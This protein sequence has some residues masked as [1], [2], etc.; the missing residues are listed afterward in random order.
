MFIAGLQILRNCTFA[1][2]KNNYKLLRLQGL[3]SK[4]N[5]NPRS[6]FCY[7]RPYTQFTGCQ[8]PSIYSNN[9]LNTTGLVNRSIQFFYQGP[10]EL[11]MYRVFNGPHFT[12]MFGYSYN[13]SYIDTI[14]TQILYNN[15][16]IE[17]ELSALWHQKNYKFDSQFFA[18]RIMRRPVSNYNHTRSYDDSFWLF[19]TIDLTGYYNESRLGPTIMDSDYIADDDDLSYGE[20]YSGITISITD[21]VRNGEIVIMN[22]SEFQFDPTLYTSDDAQ[23][24]MTFYMIKDSDEPQVSISF[25]HKPDRKIFEESS[26]FGVSYILEHKHNLTQYNFNQLGSIVEYMVLTYYGCNN[27]G[28]TELCY[29]GIEGGTPLSYDDYLVDDNYNTIHDVV[30]TTMN[31]MLKRYN[32]CGD[33]MAFY[34]MYDLQSKWY[35][36]VDPN[37]TDWFIDREYM[38]SYVDELLLDCANESYGYSGLF[39]IPIGGQR[40]PNSVDEHPKY[41][42]MDND[43]IKDMDTYTVKNITFDDYTSTTNYT[44]FERT[45]LTE[46]VYK[47]NYGYYEYTFFR[48]R[49]TYYNEYYTSIPNLTTLGNYNRFAPYLKS[50]SIHPIIADE[51][52]YLHRWNDTESNIENY[53]NYYII[54]DNEFIP[55]NFTP[56]GGLTRTAFI[57]TTY[58]PYAPHDRSLEDI[59]NDQYNMEYIRQRDKSLSAQYIYLPDAYVGSY[60]NDEEKAELINNANHYD[61]AK[62]I[63]ETPYNDYIDC[64][65]EFMN[66]EHYADYTIMNDDQRDGITSDYL[67]H[68]AKDTWPM[69]NIHA[70][71]S[72]SYFNSPLEGYKYLV[73]NIFCDETRP[74]PSPSPSQSPSQSPTRSQVITRSPTQSP[75][76][77]PS[78]SPSQSPTQSA[79]ATQSPSRSPTPSQSPTQSFARLPTISASQTPYIA[80]N[81]ADSTSSDDSSMN[82]LLIGIIVVGSIVG[83]GI[84]VIIVLVSVMCCKKKEEVETEKAPET[85]IP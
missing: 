30:N 12:N 71:S 38:F 9:A 47:N 6:Q 11:S 79:W 32:K 24:L 65:F 35:I 18:N 40:F 84:I 42:V 19:N 1:L 64:K 55:L 4:N 61:V 57:N 44:N 15:S 28:M 78:R 45:Y 37:L 49:N 48:N 23:I 60:T 21:R 56:Y 52:P 16:N 75:S 13:Y 31:I 29:D 7:T 17:A 82:P 73:F 66:Y 85:I 3:N 22:T 77:S 50:D 58:H 54:T 70:N 76:Q 10:T 83:A 41:V 68:E 46:H 33:L 63:L 36:D 80:T 27:L 67:W 81:D 53:V 69:R 51:N 72:S 25:H 26:Y 43:T 34:R 59:Y 74:T 2:Y 14:Y 39:S 5:T 62:R 20:P 8:V